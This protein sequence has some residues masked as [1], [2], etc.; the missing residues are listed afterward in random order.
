[1]LE[2]NR[3]LNEQMVLEDLLNIVSSSVG[4]LTNPTK[5]AN[6]FQSVKQISINANT[7]SKYLDFFIDAFIM[8]KVCRYDI[9]GKRYMDTPLKYYFTDIGLRNARLNFRQQ[10]E[11]HIMENVIF[12]E[13]RV[14]EYDVD[15]G[16]VEYNYQDGNG[17]KIRTQLEVDFVAN[18]ESKR[19]YIQ[20]ALSIDS[21]EK[22]AQEINSLLRVADS[23]K[24]IVVVKDDIMP[25]HDD[26]GILYIGIEQFLL[27]ED[28]VDI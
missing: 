5:L 3:I 6:T 11:N 24:K 17:K 13:L 19:Y 14:R 25:W 1:M 7:I 18:K 23:F 9:K 22:K 27:E 15:V 21:E 28:A 2:H 8:C 10:E 12:N 16:V 4:S 20:S 26:N